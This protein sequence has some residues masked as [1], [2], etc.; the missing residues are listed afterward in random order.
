M[1]S[2]DESEGERPPWTQKI[3]EATI[4]AIGSVLNTS[5]AAGDD[6]GQP[7]ACQPRGGQGG[8]RTEALPNLDVAPPLALV[9]EPVDAGDVGGLVVAAKQEK[10]LGVLDLVAKQ[11][12]VRRGE[13]QPEFEGRGCAR[14]AR[15][16]RT[17]RIVSSDCLPRST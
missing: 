17:R 13:G 2:I 5:T 14:S 8:R 15:S 3:L 16:G 10:V 12:Q 7:Q 6:F 11:L 1:S 4:E 9:I